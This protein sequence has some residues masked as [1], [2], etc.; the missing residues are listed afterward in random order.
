MI[1]PEILGNI[2]FV[3]LFRPSSVEIVKIEPFSVDI[4]LGIFGKNANVLL[5]V[6]MADCQIRI[7]VDAY[8]SPQFGQRSQ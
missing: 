4:N 7:T 5:W 8:S 1:W 6:E 2:Y 3:N